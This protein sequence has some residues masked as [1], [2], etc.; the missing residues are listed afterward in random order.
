MGR[1]YV[2]YEDWQMECC[3]TPFSVGDE[4]S[5]P[6]L[7]MDADDMLAGDWE[8][9]LSRIVGSVE[10]VPDEYGDVFRTL[11]AGPP[12]GLGLTAALNA[13]AVDDSGPE[14]A[15]P[16]RRVGLLTVERHGG[17]WPETTGRV[18]AIHLVHQQYAAL[19]PGSLTRE[20]VP[21]TRS[22][23]AMTSCPKWFGEGRSGVLVEL[24]VPGAAPPEPRDR[25]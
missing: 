18:R 17:K 4:V 16:I 20:P 25:R 3:G 8:R 2:Y 19:A 23:E 12:G 15:E 9:E 1:W 6:L 10:A 5:W 21:G 13:D 7:L 22:L 24:D 14:P 11:R